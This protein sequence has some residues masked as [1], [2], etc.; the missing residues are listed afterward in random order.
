MECRSQS[1][2]GHS[3]HSRGAFSAQLGR[4]N[5]ENA[6]KSYIEEMAK[7]GTPVNTKRSGLVIST[8]NPCLASSPDG[9]VEDNSTSQKDGIVEFKCPYASRDVTPSEAC[10]KKDFFCTLEEGQA[11][12]VNS[13]LFDDFGIKVYSK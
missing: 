1:E 5:E 6:R 9:W 10:S 12:S 2:W 11:A 8:S 13:A 3:P 4:E 7:R